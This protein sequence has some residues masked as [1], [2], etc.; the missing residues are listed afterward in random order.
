MSRY[1]IP[2]KSSK[3]GRVSLVRGK[4]LMVK[5][6]M[7]YH[8]IHKNRPFVRKELMRDVMS[9]NSANLYLIWPRREAKIAILS[10][11]NEYESM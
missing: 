2:K 8:I 10:N 6:T 7:K 11:K 5:N 9:G 1:C 3:S 4:Y